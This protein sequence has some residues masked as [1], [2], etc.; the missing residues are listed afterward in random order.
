[1]RL[2]WTLFAGAALLTFL[3]VSPAW[4]V[5][6][7][8]IMV[9]HELGHAAIVGAFR[10][11][12]FGIVIHAFGGECAFGPAPTPLQRSTIAWGGALGQAAVCVAAMGTRRWLPPDL[13]EALTVGNLAILAVNLI[14]I[15]PFDGIEAW[16]LPVHLARAR[17]RRSRPQIVPT[18]RG[19][20]INFRR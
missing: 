8:T 11:H 5:G 1:M 2:H 19:Q 10:L 7:L 13:F 17:R 12:Q 20:V 14:P 6:L 4:W 3:R 16:K 9:V 15:A 18:A